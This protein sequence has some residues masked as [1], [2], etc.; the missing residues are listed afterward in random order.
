MI[1]LDLLTG[2]FLVAT[3]HIADPYFAKAVLLLCGQDEKGTIGFIINRH[4]AS[5]SLKDLFF[6]LKISPSSLSSIEHNPLFLGGPIDMTR[7]FIL[8]TDEY[9]TP[10]SLTIMP[11]VC[12]TNTLDVL[13]AIAQDSGP[14]KYMIALGYTGWKKNQLEQELDENT[15]VIMEADKQFI[16]DEDVNTK[17]ERALYNLHI[18]PACLSPVQGR[19]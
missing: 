16:F 3:P 15:W 17:W 7:G 2:K 1:S 19:A 8:H 11:G 5:L 14:Q 18:D 13:K 10:S 9:Q 4:V 12:L 6:Q